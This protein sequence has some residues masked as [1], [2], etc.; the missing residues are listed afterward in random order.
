MRLFI[1]DDSA[2]ARRMLSLVL[3]DLSDVVV[4]GEATS[5]EEALARIREARP[6][7]VVMDWQ[8]PG[9]NGVE[10][11]MRLLAEHPH[12]H[13]VGFTSSGEPG[14]HLAFLDAGAVTVFSKE[15]AFELRDFIG[16]LVPASD[17]PVD[18]ARDPT[19]RP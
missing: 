6:D 8:M 4:V 14:T 17:R 16:A 1:V 5:G 15:Q 12:I 2:I 13:V 11:T 3:D 9:M 18:G 7:V 10:A 19:A